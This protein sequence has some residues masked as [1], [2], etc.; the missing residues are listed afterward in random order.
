M[1]ICYSAHPEDM[2]CC[3]GATKDFAPVW[4][5][6]SIREACYGNDRGRS[7]CRVISLTCYWVPFD[8]KKKAA[9]QKI[10]HT[11][12]DA[13]LNW[14]NTPMMT[15]YR[16][17]R[18]TMHW[19]QLP[20]PRNGGRMRAIRIW[21]RGYSPFIPDTSEP[22]GARAERTPQFYADNTCLVWHTTTVVRPTSG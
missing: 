3:R 12:T 21:S 15:E 7:I 10:T 18:P 2:L 20:S 22:S 11:F 4:T 13:T 5:L 16:W 1:R 14:N 19:T 9:L 8:R 17:H 6:T